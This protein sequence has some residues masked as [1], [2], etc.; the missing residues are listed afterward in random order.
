MSPSVLYCFVLDKAFQSN[1]QPPQSFRH[2]MRLSVHYRPE[3]ER[4]NFVPWFAVQG[5]YVVGETVF[6]K[7][8]AA[9]SHESLES[10]PTRENK[11]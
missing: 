3:E 4:S 2:Q 7:A 5:I 11:K 8:V 9:S 6:P 10:S 1:P